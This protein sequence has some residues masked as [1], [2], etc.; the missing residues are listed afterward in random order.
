[1]REKD[2]RTCAII[3][4]D[5]WLRMGEVVMMTVRRSLSDMFKAA[6]ST[7]RARCSS[8]LFEK[9]VHSGCGASRVT[10]GQDAQNQKQRRLET[11]AGEDARCAIARCS[12]SCSLERMGGG[13]EGTG[14][15]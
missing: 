2:A 12:C 5:G 11:G 3:S 4:I 6:I 7:R 9:H 10:I 15:A 14:A 8:R 1:M 13:G